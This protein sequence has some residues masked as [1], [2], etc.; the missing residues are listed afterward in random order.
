MVTNTARIITILTITALIAAACGGSTSVTEAAADAPADS[1]V[2]APSLA[3]APGVRLVSATDGAA[4]ADNPPDDLVIL[5][6][7]TLEEFTEGHIEGATMLDF[8]Q[9]DFGELLSELDKDVPYLLYCRSGNRSGQT[10]AMMQQLGFR[11]VSD[12]DGGILSWEMAELPT[13]TE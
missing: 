13:V 3:D 6:V 10:A 12:V 7:R 9:S 1:A 4:I 11:D 5:D 2:E 8:Y